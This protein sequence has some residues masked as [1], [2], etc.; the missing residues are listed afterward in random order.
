MPNFE[1]SMYGLPPVP[2]KDKKESKSRVPFAPK[3]ISEDGSLVDEKE[4]GSQETRLMMRKSESEEGSVEKKDNKDFE[5][6]NEQIRELSIE[7]GA[8]ERYWL[9]GFSVGRLN[10]YCGQELIEN[11]GVKKIIGAA[12]AIDNGFGFP[13]LYDFIKQLEPDRKKRLALYDKISESVQMK[14]QELGKITDDEGD[15]VAN[16]ADY[17]ASAENDPEY[18]ITITECGNS[19]N[20]IISKEKVLEKLKKLDSKYFILPKILTKK[21]AKE[22]TSSNFVEA[23]NQSISNN[24]E[25]IQR[26]LE[27]YD[28]NLHM[29]AA[30]RM[31]EANKEMIPEWQGKVSGLK[32]EI[33]QHIDKI[34]NEEGD[35]YFQKLDQVMSE[36]EGVTKLAEKAKAK[37]LTDNV[38]KEAKQKLEQVELDSD[39]VISKRTEKFK[40]LFNHAIFQ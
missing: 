24:P 1:K 36:L 11:F 23:I 7:Q 18:N 6:F 40:K 29:L 2:E 21:F 30:E 35:N 8:I 28:G 34:K 19:E 13:D 4:K 26:D 5:S 22:M 3:K 25:E 15:I 31:K 12:Q 27:K 39:A 32:V 37:S 17:K 10:M 33:M 16:K 9:D 20:V 14:K 38:I